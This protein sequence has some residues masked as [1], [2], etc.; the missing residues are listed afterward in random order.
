MPV[1]ITVANDKGGVG[2]TTTAVNLA[3]SFANM[4]KRVLLTDGDPQGSASEL[5]GINRGEIEPTSLAQAIMD[6]KP[7]DAYL[8]QGN[9]ENIDVL[10]GTLRLRD[11]I[12]QM[13]AS[14]TYNTLLKPVFAT[15]KLNQYDLVIIDTKGPNDCLLF[16]ALSCSHYYLVPIF[17]EPDAVRCIFDLLDTANKIRRGLNEK[18]SLLGMLVT[19]YDSLNSTH[20]EFAEIVRKIGKEYSIRVFANMIP[21]SRSVAGASR[22]RKPLIEYRKS[23]PVSEAYLAFAGEL[24]PLLKSTRMGRPM[25]PNAAGFVEHVE[26]I[27]A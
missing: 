26:S 3:A 16:S 14:V 22:D 24:L 9:T 27:K 17:A 21:A 15:K 2:K 8:L 1:I 4:G 11:V 13:G 23:L 19:K 6:E 12:K 18:L 5:L 25:V 10:A 20:R 7:L